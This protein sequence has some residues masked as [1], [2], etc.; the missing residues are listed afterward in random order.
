MDTYLPPPMRCCIF[1][2]DGTCIDSPRKSM[3]VLQEAA[4][5]AGLPV[6]TL[7]DMR[8]QWH[9]PW[10]EILKHF[11]GKHWRLMFN[12]FHAERYRINEE[13]Y[14]HVQDVVRMLRRKKV[15]LVLGTNRDRRSLLQIEKRLPLP[16]SS[17]A[18]VDCCD[19]RVHHKP[20]PHTFARVWRKLE[21][22]GHEKDTTYSV[23]DTIGDLAASR[24]FH[25]VGY[26]SYV[27]SA[28]RFADLGVP[29]NRIITDLRELYR[30]L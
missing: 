19:G 5:S 25:F 1:D 27:T 12:R 29:D 20:H 10:E 22:D 24:E 14:P 28:T 15:T 23:G 18:Y 6:P 4:R 11:W 16:L 9:R 2:Y 8:L 7:L 17:F 13:L 3:V 30:F 26:A 21:R